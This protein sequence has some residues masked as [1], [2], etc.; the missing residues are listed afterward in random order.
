LFG[1]SA[2]EGEVGELSKLAPAE[3]ES[4]L[5]ARVRSESIVLAVAGAPFDRAALADRAAAWT[6]ALPKGGVSSAPAT[7]P[8]IRARTRGKRV[9]VVDR[10]ADGG[11]LIVLARAIPRPAAAR[12]PAF[13]AAA[14]SIDV[15]GARAELDPA[16]SRSAIALRVPAQSIAKALGSAIG[17]LD[18]ARHGPSKDDIAA[19]KRRAA[20]RA[21]AALADPSAHAIAAVAA[22]LRGEAITAPESLSAAILDADDA[23]VAAAARVL[24]GGED[25]TVIVL[26]SAS[27]ALVKELA[28]IPGVRD[29]SIESTGD[30]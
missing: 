9:V 25:L 26:A 3:L 18:R 29:V 4:L 28:A 21:E 16:L 12:I 24:L 14:S 13:L 8:P 11:A 27:P 15:S 6:A 20:T 30:R 17:A 10:A 7:D 23:A 19:G 22:K 5:A 1:L 2:C